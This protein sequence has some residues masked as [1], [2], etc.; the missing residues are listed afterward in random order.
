MIID[1]NTGQYPLVYQ[2]F[3]PHINEES[4]AFIDGFWEPLRQSYCYYN[5][6]SLFSPKLDRIKALP[7]Y[8]FLSEKIDSLEK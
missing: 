3:N 5:M 4:I 7:E 1:K 8:Y 2:C 6:G